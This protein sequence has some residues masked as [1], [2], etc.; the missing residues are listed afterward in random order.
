LE[1]EEDHRV[2]TRAAG[3]SVAFLDQTPHEGKIEDPFKATIEVVFR[4]ELFKGEIGQWG[5]T[6][7]L[8]AHHSGASPL[9]AGTREA[10]ASNAWVSTPAHTS[11]QRAFFNRLLRFNHEGFCDGSYVHRKTLVFALFSYSQAAVLMTG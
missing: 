5:E 3:G 11:T 10:H 6:A 7:N 9:V 8:G 4:D 2:D 1:F